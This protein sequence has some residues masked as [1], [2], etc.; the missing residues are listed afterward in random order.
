MARAYH[1]DLRERVV[2]QCR[3]GQSKEA[4]AAQF[5]VGIAT[6]YRWHNAWLEEER[7]EARQGY[8]RGYGSKVESLAE[9]T[10]F[11]EETPHKTTI[12]LG[13]LWKNPCSDSTI[14]KF[15]QRIG[16]TYKKREPVS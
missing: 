15:L 9:F 3:S 2:L 12:E 7:L 4:I 8:Q 6:V 16:Y 14:S 13:R 5:K 1:R 10:A 11:I